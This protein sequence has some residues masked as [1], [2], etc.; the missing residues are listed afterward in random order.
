MPGCA[1]KLVSPP[2]WGCL[3][4]SSVG[5]GG[6]F[7]GSGL[8]GVACSTIGG[9]LL[10]SSWNP[11]SISFGSISSSESWRKAFDAK[12]VSIQCLPHL[13]IPLEGGECCTPLHHFLYY[14]DAPPLQSLLTHPH[15]RDTWAEHR[16]EN[17][18]LKLEALHKEQTMEPV[19]CSTQQ[20]LNLESWSDFVRFICFWC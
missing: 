8:L 19:S 7:P 10:R 12:I 20:N 1:K 4:G 5:V 13:W 9:G 18:Q 17:Q 11:M 16:Y 2:G 6:N 3:C 14:I 15:R